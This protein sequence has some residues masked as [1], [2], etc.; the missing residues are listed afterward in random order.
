MQ[1]T[2]TIDIDR[3]Q[4]LIK[5]D[6][7]IELIDVRSPAEF[8]Q[9]HAPQSRNIPLGELDAAAYLR[10]RPSQ[11]ED[12]PPRTI[13]LTCQTGTRGA[14][15]AQKFRDAGYTHIVNVEGGMNA[16]HAAGAN[17]VH[18]QKTISLE[19]QVRIAAGTL[20]ATGTALGAFLNPWFLVV[21]TFVGCGLV[22]AG[23]TD[24]CGMGLLL[25]RA[26]W[27]R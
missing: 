6:P 3:M 12:S 9:L 20:V 10:S 18:G 25:A 24:F 22:F 14:T 11:A 27:N 7:A 17:V 5:N 1:D 15:A 8:R 26:P 19:R 16:W 21:P 23:V 2:Q 4:A 13:Y